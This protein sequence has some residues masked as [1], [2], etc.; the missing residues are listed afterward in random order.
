M[1][2]APIA[3]LTAVLATHANAAVSVPAI[4]SVP[5]EFG[6]TTFYNLPAGVAK[7][8]LADERGKVVLIDFWATWCNPCVATIPHAVDLYRRFHAQGLEVIGHTD[9]SSENLDAFIAAKGIPYII[10]VGPDIGGAFGVTEIPH[11]ILIGRDGKVAW[12][13]PPGDLTEQTVADLI[14]KLAKQP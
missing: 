8:T 6:G 4:G 14:T 9:A 7:I 3:L 12:Q 5:P 10:S 13:G 1:R 2:I 11:A